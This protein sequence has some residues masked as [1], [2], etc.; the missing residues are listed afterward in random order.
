MTKRS[1][2]IFLSACLL[3]VFF[4]TVKAQQQ[5]A[6]P[7]AKITLDEAIRT[8]LARHPS[9]QRVRE[10]IAAADARTKQARSGYFPH[11][12]TS[13]FG[14]QGLSGAS[15]ALGL[16]GL[17]T[18]PL[19]RD[20]GASAA[21]FQ[22]VFDFGRTAHLVRSS[23]WAAVSLRRG[24]EAQQALVTLNVQRAYY[25][26][27]K[28]QR[29]T[30]VAEKVL[31]ERRLAVRQAEAFYRAQLKSKLDL[32]VAQTAASQAELDLVR[33]REALKTANAELNHAM[34]VE[35]E[36]EYEL[37]EPDLRV[38]AVPELEPL[39][40]ESLRQRPDL[41]AIDARMNADQE[42]VE[43]AEKS[44]YPKIMFLFS[45]GW[46]RFRDHSP[47]K[48][49]LG[50]LGLDL[51]VFDAGLIKNMIVEAKANLG[52]SQAARAEMAQDIRFEVQ[53]AH[54]E[55]RS[56]ME[57]IRAT[58]QLV[59]QAREALRLAQVRYRVQLGSFVELASAEAAAASA[60]AEHAQALLNYKL[61]QDVLNYTAGRR[62][63]P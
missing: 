16:R 57:S 49:L 43:R 47:S 51:P 60:E 10:E 12:T 9:L 15:G 31:A 7:R 18:S 45:G 42:V 38:D 55:L 26:A 30:E 61:A 20:V 48:L 14:K 50:A 54:N 27:L 29:L 35:G 46:V 32:S 28:G 17:V 23:E 33:A 6:S 24:L 37:Q 59:V 40:G 56:S 25:E 41:L 53:R 13:A 36:V 19:F 52:E 4:T 22:N 58:E 63:T 34:G 2:N 8:A 21:L 44:R 5:P 3:L 11:I 39:I 62:S 1:G